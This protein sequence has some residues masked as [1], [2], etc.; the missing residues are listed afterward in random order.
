M[1]LAQVQCYK[2]ADSLDHFVIVFIKRSPQSKNEDATM[3]FQASKLK[4]SKK[5]RRSERERVSK[6]D[7]E[8]EREREKARSKE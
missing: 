1:H 6:I 8:I 5:W 3:P 7:E 4:E 2:F